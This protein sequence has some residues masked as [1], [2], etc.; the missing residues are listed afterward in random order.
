MITIFKQYEHRHYTKSPQD[1][2]TN[3]LRANYPK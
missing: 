3:R 2:E 1:P